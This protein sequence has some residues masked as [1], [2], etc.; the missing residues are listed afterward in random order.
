MK[1]LREKDASQCGS[2]WVSLCGG[3]STVNVKTTEILRWK[4]NNNKGVGEVEE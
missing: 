4:K 2:S 3:E 1:F